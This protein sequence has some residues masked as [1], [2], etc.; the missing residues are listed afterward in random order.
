M[1]RQPNDYSTL[2]FVDDTIPGTIYADNYDLGRIGYAYNDADFENAGGSNTTWNQGWSYRNDGVD[3]ETCSDPV[4]NDYDV[5]WLN[6]GEWMQYTIN[7]LKTATYNI[8][9]ACA[10]NQ[11]GGDLL[12]RMDGNVLTPSGVSVPNT[13][14]WQ[15]WQKVTI[16][17]VALPAGPHVFRI[18]V[19]TGGFNLAGFR[20][21]RCRRE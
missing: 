7:V 20:L 2:P 17:N 9:I 13:G 10:A 11:T 18:Q 21:S 12:A 15:N 5:G 8:E 19:M 16:P 4:S 1:M 3:M 6:S 14:G